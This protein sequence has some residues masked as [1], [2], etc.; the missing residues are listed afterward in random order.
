MEMNAQFQAPVVL[1][2]R[3]GTSECPTNGRLGGSQ[4]VYAR[5]GEE[6]NL[7]TLPEIEGSHRFYN[8]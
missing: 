4:S 7:L 8:S 3:E 6:K 5:Y 2:L 1:P